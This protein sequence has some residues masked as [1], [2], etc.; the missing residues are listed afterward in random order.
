MQ[1]D[2]TKKRKNLK[3]TPPCGHPSYDKEGMTQGTQSDKVIPLTFVLTCHP[4]FAIL[5]ELD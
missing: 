2:D 5:S 4:L 3:T 1:R